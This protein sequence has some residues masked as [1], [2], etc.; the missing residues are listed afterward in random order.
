V[1]IEGATI[2]IRASRRIRAGEEL[3]YD[4]NT[5]GEAEHPVPLPPALPPPALARSRARIHR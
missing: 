1:D 2:W 4:Y 3:T 5:D